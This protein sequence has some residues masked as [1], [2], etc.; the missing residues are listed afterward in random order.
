MDLI[1]KTKKLEKQF[2]VT[3]YVVNLKRTK[4]LL[5]KHKKLGKWLPAGGHIEKNEL[6]HIAAIREVFEET[7]IQARIVSSGEFN[8]E[9]KGDIDTQIPK[10]YALCYQLIPKNGDTSEHIH[11]DM[12]Y[13]LEAD[14]ESLL[15]ANTSEVNSVRWCDKDEIISSLPTYDSVIGFARL[16]LKSNE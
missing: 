6:P 8:L 7:G 5:V 1:E 2:T 15:E 16:Y 10:P 12:Q 9:L 3:G 4:L 14:E 11:L 13:I